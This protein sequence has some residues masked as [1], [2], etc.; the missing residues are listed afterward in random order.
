MMQRCRA[1]IRRVFT[2]M[3]WLIP[4]LVPSC[5][6]LDAA[7]RAAAVPFLSGTLSAGIR[8][9]SRLEFS[10]D[11][12]QVFWS[13][14]VIGEGTTEW[15]FFSTWTG[16]GWTAPETVPANDGLGNGPALSPDGN[17]LFFGAERP[18]EPGGP[19]LVGI[20]YADRIGDGWTEPQP[21]DVTLQNS[22]F[23]GRPSVARSGNLYYLARGELSEMPAVVRCLWENEV[24]AECELILGDLADEI[25]LDPWV[26]PKEE[27]MLLMLDADLSDQPTFGSSDV[28]VVRRLEDDSWGPAVNLGSMVNTGHFDRS[29]SL[30]R[31]GRYLFFIR[32][33]GDVFV[34][35]EAHFHVL[36]WREI[37]LGQTE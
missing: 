14:Y 7:D 3:L 4:T 5:D 34:E 8:P 35:S 17:R 10:P 1:P 2:I 19:S 32:A 13:G 27:F 28:Y 22:G 9:H 15:M 18:A 16:S 24:Y 21:V 36:R 25:V 20:W 23:V 30:S 11:G 12:Q 6:G 37:P 33:F 29:P 31:D 26:E